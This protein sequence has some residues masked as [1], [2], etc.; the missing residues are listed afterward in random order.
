MPHGE[1]V[2]IPTSPLIVPVLGARVRVGVEDVANVLADVVEK[3]SEPETERKLHWSFALL[4]ES[5]S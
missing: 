2:P 3:K 1:D 5:V 4:S